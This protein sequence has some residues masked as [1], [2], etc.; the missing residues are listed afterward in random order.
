M[1]RGR[2]QA[3]LLWV[4][5]S[6]LCA[7][8][9]G[10]GGASAG[11]PTL[12]G[13]G[14]EGGEDG[15]GGGG[16]VVAGGLSFLPCPGGCEDEEQ[17]ERA[18]PLPRPECP[19]ASPAVGESCADLR[20][21]LLC[22]YGDSASVSCRTHLECEDGSWKRIAADAPC[23]EA[24]PGFCPPEQPPQFA[25]CTIS[26]RGPATVCSYSRNVSCSCGSQL[27]EPGAPGQW[28]CAGPPPDAR[29]PAR[30]PSQGEGCETHTLQC[31]YAPLVCEGALYDT[32]F[33][34][35][36]AWEYVTSTNCGGG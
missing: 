12:L 7:V 17:L 33:C 29:C 25:P 34:Y 3:G 21:G 15:K 6:W 1:K 14:G 23:L 31:T 4:L 10:C 36:G 11:K 24:E 8:L 13:T 18:A 32:V 35:R 2:V 16:S 28:G 20:P 30:I 27:G 26:D 9:V 19:N 5:G 22:S